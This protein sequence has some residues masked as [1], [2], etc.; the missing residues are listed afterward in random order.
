[1][2]WGII[3]DV[4]DDGIG[5]YGWYEWCCKKYYNRGEICLVGRFG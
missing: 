5:K 1:M 2:P 3:T 4:G